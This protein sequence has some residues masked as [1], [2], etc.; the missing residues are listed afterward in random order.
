MEHVL[1]IL[2]ENSAP[3]F[4]ARLANNGLDLAIVN[5]TL[6]RCIREKKWLANWIEV[7]EDYERM[8][9]D[10]FNNGG[11]FSA[12]ELYVKAG[13]AFHYA[14][15][16]HFSDL[17]EKQDALDRKDAA[18][19]KAAPLVR[20]PITITSA[21]FEG[22][23]LPVHIR[24]P[25]GRG[26]HPAILI[27]CGMDSSK[28][29]YFSMQTY[30]LDRGFAMVGFD[31]PGQN[32]V[33]K[34][35]KMRPDFHKAVSAVA[36][37]V[38]EHSEV[39]AN[40]LGLLGQSFGAFLGPS[41]LARDDRFKA[42]VV[43]GGFFD[44]SHFDWANPIREVGLPFLFGVETVSEARDLAKGYSLAGY[45]K[46]VTA[47]IMVIHGN[48]DKD[49]PPSAA[50]RI[51]DEASGPGKFVAFEDGI[52]MCHNVSHLVRPMTADWFAEHLGLQRGP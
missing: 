29:E 13:V 6:D 48:R 9:D 10:I 8:G 30:L 24:L 39:D 14:Q 20:Y 52:H 33:W 35:M 5:Q 11:A 40:R 49:A 50:K 32:Q 26:P 47:P 23:D 34:H 43:N 19:A 45:I 37:L 44:L 25:E 7:A 51:V 4:Q 1:K 3:N 2:N 36:D 17:N 21:K 41:V 38:S 16:L 27:A 31:G 42:A 18:F 22:V 28:E 12:A 15:F 46:D